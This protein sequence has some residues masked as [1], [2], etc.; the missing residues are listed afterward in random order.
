LFFNISHSGKVAVCVF[1]K[2]NVGVDIEEQTEFSETLTKRIYCREEIDLIEKQDVSADRLYTKLWTIKESL[3]KYLGTGLTLDP[4]KITVDMNEPIS[5][6]TKEYD[7][8]PLRFTCFESEGYA[9][10][11]C[12]EYDNFSDEIMWFTV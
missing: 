4:R 3:M 12:S 5:A 10:C 11:V 8:S 7:C 1:S 6:F 9:L 2:K